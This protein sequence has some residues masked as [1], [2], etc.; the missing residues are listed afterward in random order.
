MDIKVVID[1]D[2]VVLQTLKASKCKC[3]ECGRREGYVLAIQS[4]DSD[5]TV[6][7]CGMC[8]VKLGEKIQEIT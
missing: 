8:L 4:L 5:D 6:D 3:D 7:L 2:G 1:F